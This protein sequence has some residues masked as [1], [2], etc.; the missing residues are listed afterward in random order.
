MNPG[1]ALLQV[2]AGLR[3]LHCTVPAVDGET[4]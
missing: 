1:A 2:R 4:P 3:A